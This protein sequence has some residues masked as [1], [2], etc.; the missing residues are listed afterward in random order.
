[1]LVGRIGTI[2][3]SGETVIYDGRTQQLHSLSLPKIEEGV[4]IFEDNEG[5]WHASL[6]GLDEI[7]ARRLAQADAFYYKTRGFLSYDRYLSV[8][9]NYPTNCAT[10]YE[11]N[12]FF[13]CSIK[14]PGGETP[15]AT[16]PEVDSHIVLSTFE[17]RLREMREAMLYV[18]KKNEEQENTWL[19]YDEFEKRVKKQLSIDGHP[20]LTGSVRPYA[21]Y[22]ES[23]FALD[24]LDGEEI[25]GLASTYFR[26]RAVYR[27]VRYAKEHPTSFPMFQVLN[28][29][30]ASASQVR[31]VD[32]LVCK[33]G[34]IAILTGGPGTGKTTTLKV[35]VH[36]LC[37]QYN[38]PS[39]FLLSPTG[40][41]ARRISEVF[42]GEPVDVSTVHKF[43]GFGHPVLARDLA[44][45]KGADV[46]IVD[47]ASMLNLD[48]FE[49]LLT[50]ID[51]G[52]TKL[53]L[54]G[55]VDQLPAIG[56]G[57]ILHDLIKLGVHTERL[58]ENF[59]SVGTI[60]KNANKINR[61]EF[62]LEEAEDFVITDCPSSI[63]AYL[64]GM[65]SGADIVITPYKQET[66]LGNAR[67]INTVVQGR[68]FEGAEFCPNKFRA[69]DV[70]L[71]VRTNY[72]VGYFNGE[73]GRVVSY[74]PSGDY[75]VSFDDRTLTIRDQDDM[76]LG[77]AIT[78]HKSQ[79]SEYDHLEICIP[80]Y[81]DF[82][83]KRMFYTAITRAKRSVVIRASKE[84]VRKIILNCKE[85][86]RRTFL[87]VFDRLEFG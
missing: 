6:D 28:D 66:K 58:T 53:I 10:L 23:D 57:N 72:K 7:T 59:R 13:L 2:S 84:T 39:I 67:Y 18:L 34:R 77:Y 30:G 47:E 22:F 46:I 12:P 87:S 19:S 20:L 71:M 4:E 55:D 5:N 64:S 38:S 32:G 33:G 80:E 69:G 42:G 26:E 75:V 79:G 56:I 36:N 27:A 78:A 85:D 83:T 17:D 44:R 8:L 60:V 9:K 31:A 37:A 52:R 68:I 41:A 51:F 40:K 21:N 48:I 65:N 1:M 63:S 73:V 70:V 3:N 29:E 76:E 50:M 16:F 81:S 11:S 35:L 49:R 82:I 61:M 74:L 25:I 45:V 62:D 24:I 15:I 86:K 14:K 54:V 43:V